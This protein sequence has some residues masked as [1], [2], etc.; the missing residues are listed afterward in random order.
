MV[1]IVG[2]AGHGAEVVPTRGAEAA[3]VFGVIV[4]TMCGVGWER[5][6]KFRDPS[7]KLGVKRPCGHPWGL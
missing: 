4:S 2:I 6:L 7:V 3:V 1:A 5:L